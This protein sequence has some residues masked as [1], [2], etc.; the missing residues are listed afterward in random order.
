MKELIA[1]E[2]KNSL[3]V[4][5][6]LEQHRISYQVYPNNEIVEELVE[7]NVWRQ[8][9]RAASQDEQ[10]KKEIAAWDKVASKIKDK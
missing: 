3:E 4:R 5:N 2:T 9:V 10:R 1:I 7:E 8:A 6:F